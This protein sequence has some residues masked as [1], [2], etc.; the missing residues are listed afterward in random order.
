MRKTHLLLIA[1]C[2]LLTACK[3]DN[4]SEWSRFY[5]FTADDIKGH[6][7][8]NPNESLYEDQSS[9]IIV[10]YR[11]T[12]IDISASGSTVTMR[13]VIPNILNRGFTGSIDLNDNYRSDL[14]LYN[15]NYNEDVMLS[16]YKDKDR[17]A[18]LHGRVK[19]HYSDNQP[20]KNW[21][22]DVI[23]ADN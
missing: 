1:L 10:F 12:S 15:S 9:S 14:I 6:Y 8:A 17:T 21:G 7:N 3:K 20:D 11:N 23:K 16:V 5:G 18:R 19:H 2:L 4:V 22:F 13:I